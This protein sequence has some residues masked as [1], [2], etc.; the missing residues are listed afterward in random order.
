[1]LSQIMTSDELNWNALRVVNNN[2]GQ[3][4]MSLRMHVCLPGPE[5]SDDDS[6]VILPA[7]P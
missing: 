5:L 6:R 2:R 4:R 1:M 3:Y 7:Y